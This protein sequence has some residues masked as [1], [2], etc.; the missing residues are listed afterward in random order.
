M[1]VYR[2]RCVMKMIMWSWQ[3]L[4]VLYL[5]LYILCWL[6]VI[7]LSA[8]S[9]IWGSHRASPNRSAHDYR[10][11]R[12]RTFNP[13]VTADH[14]CSVMWSWTVLKLH[15]CCVVL[16]NA[17][18]HMRGIWHWVS[19]KSVAFVLAMAESGFITQY[20]VYHSFFHLNQLS[21]LPSLTV[22]HLCMSNVSVSITYQIVRRQTYV[23]DE[24]SA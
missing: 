23:C 15:S 1:T 20:R 8:K 17:Y 5:T 3:K 14:V 11:W 24:T 16:W 21:K 22:C 4:Y 9:V 18:A 2:T 13:P 7:N 19:Y 10:M 12:K 6:R